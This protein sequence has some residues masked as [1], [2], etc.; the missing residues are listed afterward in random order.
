M[1]YIKLLSNQKHTDKH[2][3]IWT[4]EAINMQHCEVEGLSY[5]KICICQSNHG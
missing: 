5:L 3:N 4:I 2:T 1:H